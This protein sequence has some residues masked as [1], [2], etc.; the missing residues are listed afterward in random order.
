MNG[1]RG[2]DGALGVVL[3]RDRRAEEREDAVTGELRERAAEALDLLAHQPHD[4]VEEELGPLGAELLRDGRRAGD[5]GDE[6][7]DHPPLSDGRRHAESYT[8][9]RTSPA[10]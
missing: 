9:A 8:D 10:G 3:V 6:H 7:R 1:E 2:P 5:V 4:V